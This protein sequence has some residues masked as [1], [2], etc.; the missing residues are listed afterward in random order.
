MSEE[1]TE[2]VDG[3]PVRADVESTGV[4]STGTAAT[5]ANRGAKRWLIG[6]LMVLGALM[7]ILGLIVGHVNRE[8]LDSQKFADHVNEIRRDEAVADAV[9]QN[10][11]DRMVENHPRL[12]IVRP[13]LAVMA[14]DIAKSDALTPVVEESAYRA[15]QVFTDPDADGFVLQITG[16][17]SRVTETLAAVAPDRFENAEDISVE[18]ASI[19]NQGFAKPIII[20]ARY[21]HILAWLLPALGL[22]FF[23]LAVYL[24]ATRW[25]TA[26]RIGA[27][28][29]IAGV[30]LGILMYF[31]RS[32]VDGISEG[33]TDGA[34]ARAAWD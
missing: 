9:G 32:T 10:V 28:V 3:D 2:P 7:L 14:T 30:I 27:T 13:L 25:A 11:A 19:S 12:E 23:A 6:T 16:V 17:A 21:I 5:P 22:A 1:A 24:S 18:L 29:A 15:H 31:G 34:F 20:G 4:D 26:T 33:P 8:M